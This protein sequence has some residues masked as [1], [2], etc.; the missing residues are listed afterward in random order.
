MKN[1][2]VFEYTATDDFTFSCTESIPFETD[3]EDVT[4]IQ[5]KFISLLETAIKENKFTFDF[6]GVNCKVYHYTYDD[7]KLKKTCFITPTIFTLDEWFETN[8]RVF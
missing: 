8:K 3:L 5:L 2:F 4:E 7:I 1:K 6:V